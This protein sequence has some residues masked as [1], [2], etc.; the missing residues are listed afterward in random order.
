MEHAAL[1]E[2]MVWRARQG[3]ESAYM[4]P[5][6]F[7]S[8]M[9][10][11]T[12]T[13]TQWFMDLLSGTYLLHNMWQTLSFNCDN[14]YSI[15]YNTCFS[16]SKNSSAVEFSG[17][18]DLQ[19]TLVSDGSSCYESVNSLDKGSE[20]NLLNLTKF[21]KAEWDL[22]NGKKIASFDKKTGAEQFV[23]EFCELL[24]KIDAKHTNL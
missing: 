4:R 1:V 13:V 10:E 24:D 19:N 7:V 5:N 17:L 12:R 9:C 15:K 22:G 6:N 21:F 16:V 20:F 11:V 2:S 8:L 18:N 3:T 23:R 14:P